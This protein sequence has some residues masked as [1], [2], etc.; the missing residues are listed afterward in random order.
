VHTSLVDILVTGS[1]VYAGAVDPSVL[2][3][4]AAHG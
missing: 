1:T 2:Y 3:A 4:A